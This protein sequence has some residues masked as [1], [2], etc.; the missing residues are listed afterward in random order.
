MSPTVEVI[1]PSG[2]FDG[3]KAK[4]LRRHVSDVMTTGVDVVLIDLQD[5]TFIDSSGLGGLISAQRIV[6]T[7]NSKLFLCSVNNQA[8]MLFE[9]TKMNQIFEIFANQEEFNNK[10]L[11]I[12]QVDDILQSYSTD[13]A[14]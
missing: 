1:Q 6:Q 13:Y 10:I 11:S 12:E 5:I 3:T 8:K 7:A 9:L 4:Q 2:L 14:N